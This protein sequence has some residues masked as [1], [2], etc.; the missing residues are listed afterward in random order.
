MTY[1][2]VSLCQHTVLPKV[3]CHKLI[4]PKL[5]PNVDMPY[6]LNHWEHVRAL[7]L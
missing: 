4:L 1:S 3:V 5:H 2:C 7:L 6:A